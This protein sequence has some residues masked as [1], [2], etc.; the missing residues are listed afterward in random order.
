MNPERPQRSTGA[1]AALAAV[2]V[3]AFAACSDTE[4]APTTPTTGGAAESPVSVGE[5]NAPTSTAST[6]TAPSPA[7][8]TSAPGA[9]APEG[10]TTAIVQITKTDG[11]TCEVCVWLADDPAERGRG[12]M[13][14]TDLGAADGMAFVFEQPT[15]G[16]FF[17]FN[18][19]TPLS[20]AWFAPDGAFVSSADM[21][22]CL[23]ASSSACQRFSASGEYQ[24]AIE[25]FQGGLPEIGIVE[26][27]R[28]EVLADTESAACPLTA[29]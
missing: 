29:A 28:A 8:D 25:V 21:D 5:T 14:V 6:S 15:S 19:V 7:P 16:A 24:L 27:S 1:W 2:A 10:F 4:S 11:S 26:G 12:L 20:I 23:E 9:V 17:M 13:G 3:L 18:T 22:P